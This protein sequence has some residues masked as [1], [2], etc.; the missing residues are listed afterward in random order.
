MAI[1]PTSGPR[2][3]F[4]RGSDVGLR[5]SRRVQGSVAE[6]YETYEGFLESA[7]I[8]CG[9]DSAMIDN[10]LTYPSVRDVVGKDGGSSV[11]SSIVGKALQKNV[12][13]WR[14]L[15]GLPTTITIHFCDRT[16]NVH[17]FPLVTR[18]GFFKRTLLNSKEVTIPQVCPG[19]SET[20]EIVANFCYGASIQ[21]D[22]TNVAEL[23]CMGEFLQMNENYGKGN[24]C[25]RSDLYMSQVVLQSWQ[26]TMVV[27]LRS[28]RLLPYAEDLQIVA[29][30]VEALAFMACMEMIDPLERIS[31][32]R[33]STESHFWSDTSSSSKGSNSPDWWMEDM[34][35]LPC[36][37]FERVI[38]AIRKQGM[39]EKYV[40][41][42]IVKF[43]DRWMFTSSTAEPAKSSV[44]TPPPEEPPI[45][46]ST[47]RLQPC[48]NQY[49]LVEAVVRLLPSEKDAVPISFLFSL[50]RC[51]LA[52]GSG[53]GCLEQLETR[54]A[55]QLE[56]AT[57]TDF[58]Y[59][60]KISE[61]SCISAAEVSCMKR[62][63]S[64]FMNQQRSL[65]DGT[66]MGNYSA[67]E[68]NSY[69]QYAVSAVAKVWDEYLAEV[70]RDLSL[71]PK[72]FLELAEVI[73]PYARATHDHL[74]QA[75]H[76][77]LHVHPHF[78][79]EERQVVCRILNCQK[80]S[81]EMCMHAVQ[82]EL[83][84]LRMVVQAMFMQQLQTRN[85]LSSN[86][87]YTV[88]GSI[89][90]DSLPVSREASFRKNNLLPHQLQSESFRSPGELVHARGGD[91]PLRT[92]ENDLEVGVA[93]LGYIL[94]R[95]VAYRQAELLKADYKAT[96]TR[97]QSL[98]DEL[99][100]MRSKIECP[101]IHAKVGSEKPSNGGSTLSA[102]SSSRKSIDVCVGP[103][104]SLPTVPE[105]LENS[106]EEEEG[107]PVQQMK[108]SSRGG[109]GLLSRAFRM[110]AL[111]SFRR[112]KSGARSSAHALCSGRHAWPVEDISE[113]KDGHSGN[114]ESNSGASFRRRHSRSHSI[115]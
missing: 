12:N 42:A 21:I 16:F 4:H 13:A 28:Q 82:N 86:L 100:I 10:N 71:S 89:R 87:H 112:K 48:S 5:G 108:V 113:L 19:G 52:C 64:S 97:L 24:I 63:V 102:N 45:K 14:E 2:I 15:T 18:S 60:F 44:P 56:L 114:L 109:L 75:I 76:V 32:P 103:E 70:A 30:C 83:M 1:S 49:N 41:Q 27:L 11:S 54:I 43:V 72:K 88:G 69:C 68:E 34:L 53:T 61:N 46:S 93:S 91:E 74:Y 94:K 107:T 23:R 38:D 79:L 73:P 85:V 62:I 7:V 92:D 51:A 111:G 105:S 67:D 8:K 22:S 58:L 33:M 39:Q 78:A 80:L 17:K 31:R 29:R 55:S 57:I 50:L 110:F 59:P 66:E 84:P 99:A 101:P 104:R 47:M 98:E 6:T 90:L 96:E 77:Y 35:R 115:S 40:S 37:V 26:D 20:F 3:D 9:N 95:D 81:Q 36:G 65:S 25:E 106:G